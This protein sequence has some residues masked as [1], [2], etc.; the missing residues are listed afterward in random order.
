MEKAIPIGY[1]WF[2]ANI[3]TNSNTNPWNPNNYFE[4]AW[5]TDATYMTPGNEPLVDDRIIG[6]TAFAVFA[7]TGAGDMWVG[8]LTTMS[9]AKMYRLLMTGVSVRYLQLTGSAVANNLSH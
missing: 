7:S 9:P 2:S 3:E 1:T 8:S 6:Q 4:N 5:F